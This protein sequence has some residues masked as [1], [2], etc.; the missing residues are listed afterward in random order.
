MLLFIC[1]ETLEMLKIA[2]K[3]YFLLYKWKPDVDRM[4]CVEITAKILKVSKKNLS[5]RSEGTPLATKNWSWSHRQSVKEVSCSCP[6]FIKK[7]NGLVH[8]A[9]RLGKKYETSTT[10]V[11][12]DQLQFFSLMEYLMSGN[13]DFSRDLKNSHIEL[14]DFLR[15]F[16]SGLKLS[17]KCERRSFFKSER[18]FQR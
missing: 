9:A 12:W 14:L 3:F 13:I 6:P 18:R 5:L 7:W 11:R 16:V 17:I 1:W 8:R 2:V 15:T 10:D 4:N